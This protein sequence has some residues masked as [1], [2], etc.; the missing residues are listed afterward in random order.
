MIRGTL[1]EVARTVG[2]ELHGDDAAFSGVS[3]DTRAIDPGQLFIALRGPRFDAHELLDAAAQAGAAGAVVMRE[4]TSRLPQVLVGD[5]R[6]ALADLARDW[7]RRFRIPVIAVTGSNGKTTTKEMLAAILRTQGPV[8]ATEGNLNNDI[9]VPLTLFRLAD[10]HHHAVIEMGANRPDDIAGLVTIAEPTVALV[11][12]VAPAHLEGFGDVEGV[13]RA[14]GRIYSRLPPG[15]IAVV[16]ADETWAD[17]WCATAGG[18]R[19]VSFGVAPGADITAS[20]VVCGELGT[21]TRFVLH[22]GKA[23]RAVDL[24][25]DGEHNVRNALAAAAVAHAVG[26]S[27]DDIGRG[28]AQAARVKGRLVVKTA[29]GGMRVIDDSYNANPASLAAAIALLARQPRERWL[30]FGDMGELGAAAPAAHREVGELARRA[31]I[32]RLFGVGPQARAAVDAFGAGGIWCADAPAALVVLETLDG[33][34]ATVLI[35]GSRYMQL[36][37][38]VEG[39]VAS[40]GG[41]A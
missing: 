34:G 31:G 1:H 4:T 6:T 12:M 19:I 25:F 7:R 9:G 28:L 26:V 40:D 36:E 21:G 2:G 11:T 20:A 22:I 13:A 37:R 32:E 29:R 17:Q 33:A 16:N 27:I 38:I 3:T 8:L 30:V 41:H 18:A 14:K 23:R 10:A 5:T 15:G 39:L 35:K 24:P